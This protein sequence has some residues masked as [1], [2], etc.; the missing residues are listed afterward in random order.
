MLS[1]TVLILPEISFS[2]LEFGDQVGEGAFGI[3]YKGHWK[4]R[5]MGVAIKRVPGRINNEEV[6]Q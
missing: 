1:V 5:D 2:D 6:R 3:V 4:S